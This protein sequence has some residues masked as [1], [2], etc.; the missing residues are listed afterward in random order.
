[1]TVRVSNYE[2]LRTQEA[3]DRLIKVESCNMLLCML[4]ARTAGYL[5][6]FLRYEF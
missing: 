1:M 4:P 6:S 5:K 2:T 3:S